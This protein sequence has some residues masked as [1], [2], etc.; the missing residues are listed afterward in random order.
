MSA[1]IYFRTGP[2]QKIQRLFIAAASNVHRLVAP[3]HAL[4]VAKRLL[5][6]P[7]RLPAKNAEPQGLEKSLVSTGYGKVATY[8]LGKG[9]VWLLVHGWSGASHQ[10]YPLMQH[11]ADQGFTAVAFDHIAHGASEGSASHLPAFIEGLDCVAKQESNVAGV[12]AHSMGGA[13]LLQSNCAAIINQPLLLIAPVLNYVENMHTTVRRSGY[14][15]KLFE[16]VTKEVVGASGLQL[17]HINP[18]ARLQNRQT[19]SII[20]HD[21]GDRL[22]NFSICEA[23]AAK[24]DRVQLVEAPRHG[25]GRIMKCKATMVAFNQLSGALEHSQQG[26]C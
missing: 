25:H 21:P 1:K 20:V 26:A 22:A 14:S 24:S 2:S 11:I 23:A 8:R 4:T 12:I 6:T 16:Q 13:A 9:P 15:M 10:F 18:V 17:E 19:D 3:K 5:L 7:T